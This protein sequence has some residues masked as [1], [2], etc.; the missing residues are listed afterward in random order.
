MRHTT[1]MHSIVKGEQQRRTDRAT[2]VA[3]SKLLNILKTDWSESG[4][5]RVDVAAAELFFP[6]SIA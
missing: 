6:V 1:L 2:N 5:R 3:I 4:I